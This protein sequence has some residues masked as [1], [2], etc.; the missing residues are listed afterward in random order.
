MVG[1]FTT[2]DKDFP[3]GFAV[4]SRGDLTDPPSLSSK[5]CLLKKANKTK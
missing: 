4:F 2:S 3:I 5:F 1:G